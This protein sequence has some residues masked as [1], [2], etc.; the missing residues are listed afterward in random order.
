MDRIEILGSLI[1]C[2]SSFLSLALGPKEAG[3]GAGV[4]AE[5]AGGRGRAG[6]TPGTN[7]GGDAA[8]AG[9]SSPS[10]TAATAMLF[11]SLRRGSAPEA[12]ETAATP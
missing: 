10:A 4:V 9:V 3:A 7:R 6:E 8:A 5:D 2:G 12:D 11:R 1:Y